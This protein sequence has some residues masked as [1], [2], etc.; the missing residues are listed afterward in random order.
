MDP[1]NQECLGY[2]LYGTGFVSRDENTLTM[3]AGANI[4]KHFCLRCPVRAE[5]ERRQI[6]RVREQHPQA[7]ECYDRLMKR[8]IDKG[9][10]ELLASVGLAQDG[11]NPFYD[12]AIESFKRGHADRGVATGP[13]MAPRDVR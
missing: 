2:Y 1:H 12:D 6:A 11:A 3:I 10:S 9:F 5:C 7:A 13:I 4:S 8:A